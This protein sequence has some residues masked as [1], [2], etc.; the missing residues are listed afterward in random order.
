MIRPH[1]FLARFGRG[2]RFI[3]DTNGANAAVFIEPSG[4]GD[5]LAVFGSSTVTYRRFTPVAPEVRQCELPV[6]GDVPLRSVVTGAAAFVVGTILS[7]AV[8]V[9]FFIVLVPAVAVGVQLFT[10]GVRRDRQFG[11]GKTFEAPDLVDARQFRPP[12]GWSGTVDIVPTE[13]AKS[14]K[15]QPELIPLIYGWAQAHLHAVSLATEIADGRAHADRVAGTPV[16][17]SVNAKLT[18]LTDQLELIAQEQSWAEE[19]IRLE[20][21]QL[22]I[23]DAETESVDAQNRAQDW[24]D[25]EWRNQ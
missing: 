2:H 9:G 19:D 13:W 3:V 24:L 16:E 7:L 11:P 20:L 6:V 4:V 25:D 23:A 17:A 21:A 10:S 5:R 1:S 22:T 18:E 8:N 12:V 15:H 14:T